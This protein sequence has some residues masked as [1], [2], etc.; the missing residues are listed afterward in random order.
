MTCGVTYAAES[1]NQTKFHRTEREIQ[2]S[3]G[4]DYSFPDS[5]NGCRVLKRPES[6]DRNVTKKKKRKE[7]FAK[8]NNK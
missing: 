8:L 6:W 7:N 3:L 2:I 1:L 5:T 4:V